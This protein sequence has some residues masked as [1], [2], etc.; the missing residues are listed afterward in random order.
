MCENLEKEWQNYVPARK[1][2]LLRL[3]LEQ[4]KVL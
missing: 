3:Q 4:A 1:I 2:K